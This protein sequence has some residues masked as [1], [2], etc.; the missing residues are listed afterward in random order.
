MVHGRMPETERNIPGLVRRETITVDRHRYGFIELEAISGPLLPV[1]SAAFFM[2]I[3]WMCWQDIEGIIF[4]LKRPERDIL[5]DIKHLLHEIAEWQGPYDQR[6]RGA[7]T[8]TGLRILRAAMEEDWKQRIL[9]KAW[10]S[11][12]M[13]AIND[14]MM[15][16]ET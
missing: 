10:P 9:L 15:T 3:C 4:S 14:R 5:P 1:H 2:G 16:N 7:A 12:E 8:K 13:S 11:T 6:V